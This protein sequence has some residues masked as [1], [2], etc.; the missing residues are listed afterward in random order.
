MLVARQE[1]IQ[2]ADAMLAWHLLADCLNE[3]TT[4]P[5]KI[6]QRDCLRF[7]PSLEYIQNLFPILSVLFPHM[8]VQRKYKMMLVLKQQR[9]TWESTSGWGLPLLNFSLAS[10]GWPNILLFCWLPTSP[11]S[12]PQTYSLASCTQ[13]QALFFLKFFPYIIFSS[14]CNL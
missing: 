13:L 7:N 8:Y 14:K 6:K 4:K 10:E 5:R 11:R 12:S 1:N 2:E 9:H 3:K